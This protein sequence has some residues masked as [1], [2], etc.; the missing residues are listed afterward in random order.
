MV[1]TA[2]RLAPV[3]LAACCVAALAAPSAWAAPSAPTVRP[4]VARQPAGRPAPAILGPLAGYLLSNGDL[5][6]EYDSNGGTIG[7]AKISTGNYLVTLGDLGAITGGM[8]QA[9]A[10]NDN[11]TCAVDSWGPSGS[12]LEVGV[13]CYS[14]TGHPANS[15]FDL[16]VTQPVMPP[17]GTFDYSWVYRDTSSGPLTGPYQYNSAHKSNSVRHLGTGRY[18]VTLGGPASTG[19]TGTVKVSAYGAGGG[20]CAGSGW[21]GTKAGVTVDVTC[22][23]ASGA[24]V[25]RQFDVTYTA[26]SNLMGLAGFPTANA[27]ISASGKVQT[28]FNS[29]HKAKVTAGHSKR[30]IYQVQFNGTTVQFSGGDVQVTPVTSSKFH[31]VVVKWVAGVHVKTVATVRCFDGHGHPVN[32]AFAIQFVQG[33]VIV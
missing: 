6:D 2:S 18:Q 28:Q 10:V 25:N 26:R 1:K 31:C 23:K 7:V 3:L 16:I 5:A 32:S 30:G 13:L 4:M 11:G 24:P 14:L 19:T 8:V 22:Y 29:E 17:P 9:T 12:D 15:L 27:L 33:F 21:H 20:D